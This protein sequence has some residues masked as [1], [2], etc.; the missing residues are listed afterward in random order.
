LGYCLFVQ[1]QPVQAFPTQEICI[2]NFLLTIYGVRCENIYL[3]NEGAANL[4]GGDDNNVGVDNLN[5]KCLNR[6]AELH[7]NTRLL[8]ANEV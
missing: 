5:H 6:L 7:K 8:H 1:N 2:L 4:S 3:D